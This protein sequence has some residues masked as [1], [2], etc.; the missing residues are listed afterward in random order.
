MKIYDTSDGVRLVFDELL[1]KRAH[2]SDSDTEKKALA[3][4][5]ERIRESC[6]VP[7]R[8]YFKSKIGTKPC[9]QPLVLVYCNFYHGNGYKMMDVD[10]VDINFATNQFIKSTY[11]IPDDSPRCIS[12]FL[13][14]A[15]EKTGAIFK[16]DKRMSGKSHTEAMLCNYEE[17][18][19]LL[20][21]YKG[22]M[23][24]YN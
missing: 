24:V 9:E 1:P 11:M 13:T 2:P 10:N 19:K 17:F 5:R 21:K 20:E 12:V 14:A 4:C 16:E 6:T 3:K 22:F 7:Y 23:Q 8:E 15:E 18:T